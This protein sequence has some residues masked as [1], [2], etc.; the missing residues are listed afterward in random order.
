MN[1]HVPPPPKSQVAPLQPEVAEQSQAQLALGAQRVV[2]E[3]VLI[4][5]DPHLADYLHPLL[6]QGEAA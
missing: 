6:T 5:S 3:G 2:A 4:G 1:R